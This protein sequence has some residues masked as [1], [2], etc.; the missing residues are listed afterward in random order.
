MDNANDE[1]PQFERPVYRFSVMENV[2]AETL[3][4]TVKARDNDDPSGGMQLR[5]SIDF[6]TECTHARNHTCTFLF[7]L[8]FRA[9]KSI[10]KG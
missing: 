8:Q 3:V 4:G 7:F 9:R 1:A 10:S 2:A 5:Y 6:I